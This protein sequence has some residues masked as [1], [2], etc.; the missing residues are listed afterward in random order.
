MIPPY[1]E[2]EL[3]LKLNPDFHDI[4]TKLA[5]AMMDAGNVPNAV[6]ELKK[7]IKERPNYFPASMNLGLCYF[8]MN[9]YDEARKIWEKGS[10][11]KTRKTNLSPCI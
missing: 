2:Y 4:R 9:K 11:R 1:I 5:T 10:Q 6:V 8:K 3:A 7:V